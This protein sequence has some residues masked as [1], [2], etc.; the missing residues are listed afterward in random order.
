MCNQS[1]NKCVKMSE[2]KE[3]F[4]ELLDNYCSTFGEKKNKCI[5]SQEVYDKA[6][7]TLQLETRTKCDEG[8]KFKHWC[9]NHFKL[10]TIGSRNLLYCSK[11]K[12]YH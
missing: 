6:V 2:Q 11:K 3:K 12:L 10:E 9:K 4:N 7:Q 5:I 8:A 1:V